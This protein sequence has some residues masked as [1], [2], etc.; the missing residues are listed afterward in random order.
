ML[1]KNLPLLYS[2][3]AVYVYYV[4]MCGCICVCVEVNICVRECVNTR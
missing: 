1:H 4:C 3:C 2:I